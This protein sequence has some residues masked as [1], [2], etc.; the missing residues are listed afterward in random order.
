MVLV[1]VCG[2]VCGLAKLH[3]ELYEVKEALVDLDL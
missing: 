1:W 2:S 3:G